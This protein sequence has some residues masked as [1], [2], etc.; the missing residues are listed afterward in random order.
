MWTFA[1]RP[2]VL[3]ATG[4]CIAAIVLP[5]LAKFPQSHGPLVFS[6][7]LL[8]SIL[9]FGLRLQHTTTKQRAVMPPSFLII[10]SALMLFGAN[11][12]TLVA[13]VGA[14]TAVLG[15]PERGHPRM[16]VFADAVA[17]I[18]A[19]QFG[20]L[21]YQAL[22]GSSIDFTWPWSGGPI[23]ASVIDYYL[24]PGGLAVIFIP[25]PPNLRFQCAM[26]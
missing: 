24:R 13:A 7:L 19:A 12:A 16:Q 22:G 17:V 4:L 14:L 15:A 18:A 3:A 23:A 1:R 6:A 9:T 10:F 26:L 8:G 21:T 11:G 5:Q 20:G 2:S 25:I